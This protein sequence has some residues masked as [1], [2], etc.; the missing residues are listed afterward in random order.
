MGNP[1]CTVGPLQ[2]PQD[3][4]YPVTEWSQSNWKHAERRVHS[5]RCR[6]FRATQE[7]RWLQGRHL[8][9]LLLRR[10]SNLVVSVRRVTPVNQGKATPGIDGDR[11]TTPQE[12]AALV[13]ELRQY[14]PWKASPVRRLSLPKANGKKRPLSM[15]TLRDRVVQMVVKNALEPRFEAECEA[16]SYGF[17]P[18]RCG[19][20]AMEAISVALNEGAVGRALYILDA[21]IQGAFDALSHDFLL[22]RLGSLPG[23]ELIKQW[24]KAGYW[25]DGTLHPTPQGTPQGGVASPLVANIALD[26]LAKRLGQGYRVVRYAD[27]LL[28]MAKSQQAIDQAYRVVVAFLAERGVR[29][30][31]DKTRLR[32]R[33]EGFDYLGFHVQMRGKKLLITPQKQQGTDLL[34][35]LRSWL[36]RHQAVSAEAVLRHLTPLRRG[37]ALYYC[38]VGSNRTFQNGEH[39]RWRAL[40]QWAKHRHPRKPRRWIYRRYFEPGP[41]GA[42]FYA[43][44]RDRRGQPL[45]LR[46]AKIS[47][48]PIVRQVQV[49]GTASPD[50]P[51]LQAYWT[52]RRIKM[53]RRRLAKGSKLY[54]LAEAQ[55]WQC[56]GCGQ[57]LFDGQE[58]HL[59]HRIPVHAGGRDDVE[60]L[61]WLHQVC[62]HQ[63][64]QQKVA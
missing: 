4:A 3:R 53:G 55:R 29:L 11:A 43:D 15:P 14:Q 31:Q 58:V 27:D 48:I 6:I 25:E 37:W 47:R 62:H 16:Q 57:T 51:T 23:R 45:R 2:A 12:R 20:D 8:R 34:R 32:H 52:T 26:G 42:T 36:K 63:Q 19:Q 30:H 18:G 13:H 24:L 40:W 17:R 5:L 44:S 64:H 46:L 28:V 54:Q 1:I 38:H 50:D 41:S 10:Y 39:H 7:Q 35:A 22:H 61:Q 21:D 59:H 56:L 33:T 49:K 60:N 9:K